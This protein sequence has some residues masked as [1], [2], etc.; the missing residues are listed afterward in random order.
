[1]ATTGAEPLHR[2]IS[3]LKFESFGHGQGDRWC[4][5]FQAI[6][7]ATV[8]AIEMC[9]VGSRGRT[10]APNPVRPNKFMHNTMFYKPIQYPVERNPLNL[11]A[12]VLESVFYFAVCEGMIGRQKGTQYAHTRRSCSPSGLTNH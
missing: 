3:M 1:M 2:Y 12:T 11:S 6:D 7:L 4:Q 9:M 10:K 5:I 8:R